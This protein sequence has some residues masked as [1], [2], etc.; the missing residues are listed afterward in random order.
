MADY[1]MVLLFGFIGIEKATEGDIWRAVVH[2]LIAVVFLAKFV[3]RIAE[4]KNG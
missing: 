4:V 3:G 2:L 1:A